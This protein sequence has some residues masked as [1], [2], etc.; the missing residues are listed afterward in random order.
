M[1]FSEADRILT[2][3]TPYHGKLRL[4]A[5]GVRRPGSRMGGHLELFVH[6]KV[7]VA[8]G[9]SLDLVNQAVTVDAHRAVRED[10]VKAA[11]AFHIAE[12]VD[13]FL[14]ENDNHPSVFQLLLDAL[15][16]LEEGLDGGATPS[17]HPLPEGEGTLAPLPLGEAGRRPA[18][19]RTGEGAPSASNLSLLDRQ[20][21]L[22]LLGAVGFRPQLT[23]CVFCR[24]ELKPETNGYSVKLGGVLC[25]DC[26]ASQPSARGILP[27][28]LKL[29]R[30]LQ[31]TV[32]T[33]H[34]TL[35]APDR[36]LREAEQVLREQMEF[37]LERR[38]RAADFL[39]R[40]SPSS[41]SPPT[42]TLPRRG[43]GD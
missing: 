20:F 24:A 16:G 5:K 39:R 35:A 12:L 25:P 26:F 7:Q 30:Y 23:E 36:V 4:L 17:P 42:L 15:S 21:E 43:G 3:L 18:G 38:L 31:R 33:G 37:A 19:P 6:A 8:R 11:H 13:G 9:R 14:E 1:D 29:L 40:V 27:D 32:P 41:S 22:H 2:V 10:I 28:A 34:M